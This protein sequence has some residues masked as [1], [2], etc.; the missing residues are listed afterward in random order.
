[1]NLNGN[2]QAVMMLIDNVPVVCSNEFE[3][4]EQLA[5]TSTI[6]LKNCYPE[7]W[8]T[9]HD[10]TSKFYMPKDYSI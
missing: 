7:F 3:I 2:T 1:M 6:I 10:Y 5:N 9:T 4:V 8:E